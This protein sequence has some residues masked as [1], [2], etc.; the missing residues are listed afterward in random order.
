M[1]LPTNNTAYDGMPIAWKV[2][3]GF[4]ILNLVRG[5]IHFFAD[6]GGAGRIA[7]IDLSQ[8]REVIVCLFAALGAGQLGRGLLDL[9]IGLRYRV[10]VHMMLAV[11][12]FTGGL[13]VVAVWFYKPLPVSAPGKFVAPV[14]LVILVLAL[15]A[16]LR[17][18]SHTVATS[19]GPG[20]E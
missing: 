12:V 8:Q 6:D 15:L 3:V 2:L 11:E 14:V 19:S 4:G 18:P 17:S 1:R 7:G 9:F 13:A 5:S 10:L 20:K 16:S